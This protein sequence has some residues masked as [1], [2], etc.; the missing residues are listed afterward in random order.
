MVEKIARI[1]RVKGVDYDVGRR[2]DSQREKDEAS[3]AFENALNRV[4][5]KEKKDTE[6]SKIPD[7]Y[8][9]ELSSIGTQSLFYF[10]GL[11]LN[12]LLT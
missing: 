10:G 6:E 2:Y 5:H 8:K 7:A 4:L 3:S 9:L 1:A 11:N 12:K